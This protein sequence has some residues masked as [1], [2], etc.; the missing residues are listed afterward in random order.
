VSGNVS[1]YNATGAEPILPTPAI[2]AVG[3]IED[4]SKTARIA[5]PAADLTIL[6]IGEAKGEIGQS[7]Y[8]REIH[9]AEKG[10]P[11]EVDLKAERRNGDFVR[12]LITG[13]TVAACHDISDGGLLVALAEMAMAGGIGAALDLPAETSLLFGEDQARYIIATNTPE[14]IEAKAGAASVPIRRLGVTG[15]DA[16]TLA[17][18]SIAVAALKNAHEGWLPAYMAGK[19]E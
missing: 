14:A 2:G 1:L 19:A 9:D 7:I 17:G 3:L 4:A 13:G 15:G 5:F 16:L 10:A 12:G 6:M 18:D 11:P 8:L